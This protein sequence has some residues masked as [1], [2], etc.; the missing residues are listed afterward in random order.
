MKAKFSDWCKQNLNI[1][2]QIRNTASKIHADVNQHYDIYPY[3]YHLQMV[4][5]E[6]KAMADSVLITNEEYYPS[7]VF[8]AYFHDSIE[9]ARLT[10]N[11][12]KKIALSILSNEDDAIKAAEYA[13]ALTNEKAPRQ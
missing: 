12:V 5:D 4:F 6:F 3:S 9:D 2:T 8:G 7:L 13:Y 10:Y 11:D 1:V